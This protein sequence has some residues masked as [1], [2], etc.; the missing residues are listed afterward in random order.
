[1]TVLFA[2]VVC[3]V[4]MSCVA[5]ISFVCVAFVYRMPMVAF[6]FGID[7]V[8]VLMTSVIVLE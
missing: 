4:I 2:S 8:F 1:M 6:T 7:V 3:V 5:V